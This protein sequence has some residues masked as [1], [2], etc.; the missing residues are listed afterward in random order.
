MAYRIVA[1][2]GLGAH[3]EY[4]WNSDD[5]NRVHLLRD[6]IK[7]DFPNTRILAFA[8]NSDWLIDAPVKSAQQIGDRL[9]DELVKHRLKHLVRTAKSENNT[10]NRSHRAFRSS[11]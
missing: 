5:G 3:P 11:S 10:A 1:V 8:H 4:T 2:H 6:L 9:L 7:N